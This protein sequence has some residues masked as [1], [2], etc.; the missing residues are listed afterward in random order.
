M[1]YSGRKIPV[2]VLGSTGMVGQRYLHLLRD[3]PWFEV[4]FV[5]A[6]PESCNRSYQEAVASRWRCPLP[7]PKAVASLPVS[8]VEAFH[9]ARLRC[10]F[11]F[12][13]LDTPLASVYEE[14]YAA[15]G[16]PVLSVAAAHRQDPDVPMVVPEVN[17]EH[18]AILSEQKKKR[19]WTEGFLTTKPNCTVQSFIL[20]FFPLHK[21]FGIKKAFVTTL[22]AASGAGAGLAAVDMID[23]LIPYIQG[24]EQKTE[25]EPLKM[26]SSWS[27][28]SL[29]PPQGLQ[30]SAHCNRVPLLDGHTVCVSLEFEEKPTEA[31]ILHHWEK[32]SALPQELD[33]PS[34]PKRPIIY[35]PLP[36]RPQPRLDREHEKGMAVTVGRLRPCPILHY[37]FVALSHN[38][39][40][41]AAGGSILNAEYLAVEK[42]L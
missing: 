18:F 10:A 33:L 27:G 23:N 24:E 3:H 35:T 42:F 17:P 28:H 15:I 38:T 2:G 41:G 1:V 21:A 32:F 39:I 16:L 29:I 9:E 7:I 34:A 20:P 5:T 4:T 12:S 14:K 40:R 31:A 25:Q 36:D 13:A 19:G 11:V 6:S 22:Q 37:R 30:V 26:L 8:S